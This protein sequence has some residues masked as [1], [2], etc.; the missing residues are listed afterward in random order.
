MAGEELL[1]LLAPRSPPKSRRQRHLV[2]IMALLWSVVIT[3]LV[4]LLQWQYAVAKPLPYARST[5]SSQSSLEEAQLGAV[6]SE[7]DICSRIGADLLKA[8]GNAADAV[9]VL[10]PNLFVSAVDSTTDGWNSLLHWCS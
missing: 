2:L 3:I 4:G 6:A 9:R 10:P 1:P 5:R 8:G 7:S